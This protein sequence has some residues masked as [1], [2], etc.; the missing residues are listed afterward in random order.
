MAPDYTLGKIYT[1][2]C[3]TNPEHIYVGT[4]IQPLSKRWGGHI[5]D[6]KKKSNRLIYV[7]INADVDGWD[8]WYIELYEEFSCDNREQLLRKEGEIVRKIGT[9]NMVIAGQTSEEYRENNKELISTHMKNY[10]KNNKAKVLEQHKNY[11]ENNAEKI[12]T[13][14]KK[15]IVQCECGCSMRKKSLARH[16]LTNKHI[17]L[18]ET[19]E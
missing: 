6:S 18:M 16:K 12:S 3:R 19:I 4:T 13:E 17:E 15:A 7:T 5:V 8:N 1:I 10:Y 14:S 9:L 11:Y 2:R